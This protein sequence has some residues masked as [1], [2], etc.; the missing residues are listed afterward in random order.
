MPVPKRHWHVRRLHQ[1]ISKEIEAQKAAADQAKARSQASRSS[2]R[3][4][5]SG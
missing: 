4:Y 2:G 1:K 5:R 3:R